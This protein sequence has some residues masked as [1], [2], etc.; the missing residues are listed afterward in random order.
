[1]K[2]TTTNL[3]LLTIQGK[4]GNLSADKNMRQRAVFFFR[5]IFL[6]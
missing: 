3:L 1:M 4:L 2:F 6:F 5:D